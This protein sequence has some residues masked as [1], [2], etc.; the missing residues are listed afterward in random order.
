MTEAEVRAYE[1]LDR[2]FIRATR[3]LPC[4]SYERVTRAFI[5]SREVNMQGWRK[6]NKM[7]PL[8]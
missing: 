5:K 7:R 6:L 3:G 8:D 4:D 2:A 1:K